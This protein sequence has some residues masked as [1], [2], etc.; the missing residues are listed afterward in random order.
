MN[1]SI[2]AV[3]PVAASNRFQ[4]QPLLQTSQIGLSAR[5]SLI[6]SNLGSVKKR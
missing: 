6:S 4:K 5:K 3:A 2:F 1:K